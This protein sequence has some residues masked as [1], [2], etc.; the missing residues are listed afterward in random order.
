[1]F[2]GVG[3]AFEVEDQTAG[4]GAFGGCVPPRTSTLFWAARGATPSSNIPPNKNNIRSFFIASLSLS[5]RPIK[6]WGE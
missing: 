1:M 5:L 2:I 3:L 6:V 4:I